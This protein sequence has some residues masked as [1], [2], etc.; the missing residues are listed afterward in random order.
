MMLSIEQDGE[1]GST[2]LSGLLLEVGKF[3]RSFHIPM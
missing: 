1:A 2:D 3:T